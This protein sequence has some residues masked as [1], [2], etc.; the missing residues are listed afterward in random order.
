MFVQFFNHPKQDGAASREA[1]HPVFV[2]VPYIRKVMPGAIDDTFERPARESDKEEFAQ[3]WAAFERN[4]D[5]SITGWRIEQWPALTTAQVETLKA[6]KFFTVESL[7]EAPDRNLQFMGGAG[8]K[9]QA[10]AALAQAK[11]QAGAQQ[12]ASQLTA[13]QNE[14][15]TLRKQNASLQAELAARTNESLDDLRA[16]NEELRRQLDAGVAKRGP[17]RPRK[18]LESEDA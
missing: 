6:A 3:A 7:A 11:E 17:G 1:G 18:N 14:L 5:E 16:E 4:Q 15:D 8:L 13:I 9:E 2:D 12:F 10:K